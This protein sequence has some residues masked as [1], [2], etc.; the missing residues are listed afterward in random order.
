MQ[1]DLSKEIIE[2]HKIRGNRSPTVGA[3]PRGEKETTS[4]SWDRH[5]DMLLKNMANANEVSGRSFGTIPVELKQY[6]DQPNISRLSNAL[7]FW[8]DSRHFT[9][10]LSEIAV[11]YLI[12]S[13]T[14]VA[15]ELVAPKINLLVSNN[16]SS[17]T[18]EH[19]KQR[20]FSKTLTEKYWYT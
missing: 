17:Q 19:I 6:L 12:S 8:T 3:S 14:S 13:V 15:S 5:E 11:K 20:V 10:V 7:K 9:P 16:R 1:S 4:S 2:V 18:A